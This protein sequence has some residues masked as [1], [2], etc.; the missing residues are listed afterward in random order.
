MLEAMRIQAL[1][2]LYN[3]LKMSESD[4]PDDLEKWYLKVK[5]EFPKK[6]FP[7]LVESSTQTDLVYIIQKEKMKITQ[8]LWLKICGLRLSLLFRL[9]SRPVHKVPR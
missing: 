6:I 2:Y 7:F 3:Q 4:P 8:T 9:L 5:A 1:D